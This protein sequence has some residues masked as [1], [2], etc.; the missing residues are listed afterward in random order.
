MKLRALITFLTIITLFGFN[1]SESI[2]ITENG[3]VV[4]I[5]KFKFSRP[6]GKVEH[7]VIRLITKDH[8]IYA[9]LIKA[10]EEQ[11]RKQQQPEE[12]KKE[13]DV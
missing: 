6:K 10:Q 11:M 5:K 4:K 12:E 8:T 2:K 13:G 3:N 9:D 7:K 1:K